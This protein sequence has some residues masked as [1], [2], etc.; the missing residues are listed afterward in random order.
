MIETANNMND[1][2]RPL[3][4]CVH[5]DLSPGRPALGPRLSLLGTVRLGP[6]AMEWQQTGDG[7][8]SIAEWQPWRSSAPRAATASRRGHS[9]SASLEARRDR[10]W[11]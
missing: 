11:R 9:L 6:L 8:S 1:A 2:R 3:T 10:A 5:D 7:S 4:L